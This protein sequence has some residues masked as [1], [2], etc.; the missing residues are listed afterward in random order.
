MRIARY[1]NERDNAPEIAD[2]EWP[3][4]VERLTRHTITPCSRTPAPGFDLCARK[5]CGH[6]S[7]EAWSPA[8]LNPCPAKCHKAGTRSDCGGGR[9]HRLNANVVAITVAVFDLDHLPAAKLLEVAATI[10]GSGLAYIMHSTHSHDLEGDNACL[11]LMLPLS[12]AV[13]AAEYPKLREAVIRRFNLPADPQTKDLARLFFLPSCPSD[14]D[15]IAEHG[16]GGSIAVEHFLAEAGAAPAPSAVAPAPSVDSGGSAPSTQ[17]EGS[18]VDLEALRDRLRAVNKAD[19]KE[20]ARRILRGEPLA[21]EGSRD[22]TLNRAVSLVACAVPAET[23]SEAILELL[24]PSVLAMPGAPPPGDPDWLRLAAYKLERARER[25]TENDKRRDEFNA[26]VRRRLAR[27]SATSTVADEPDAPPEDLSAPYTAEQIERWM[28]EQGAATYEEFERRWIV[29]R[30]KA[31]WIFVGGAYRQPITRD[32]LDVSLPRDLARAPVELHKITAEGNP[33]PAKVPELLR[34]YA[35]VARD[36]QAS[37]ALQR[38]FYDATS[39]TF[40]EAVRPLRRITP[41]E[42]PEVQTWLELLGAGFEGT[43]REQRDKLLDWIATVSRL[44]RQSCALYFDGAPGVGKGL[45]ANGL[46][47]LWTTGGPTEL[48]RVLGGFNDSLINCPLL[49][50][51]ESLPAVKGITAELRRLIGSTQ[52]TLRRLYLPACNLDGSIRMIIAGN[53]DRLLDTGE[54]LSTHD[55]EAVAGRF[56]YVDAR[57]PDGEQHPAAAYLED[58]G[59]TPVVN[60]WITD[61]MIAEHALFLQSTRQVNEGARFIVEGK[62]AE[63]HEHLATGSGIAGLVCEWLVRHLSD[64]GTARAAAPGA[65]ALVFVGEGEVWA[66]TEALA[67][68]AAWHARV[69]SSN[70]PSATK[71]GRALRNLSIGKERVK[72]GEVQN[73]YHRVKPSLLLSWAERSQVGDVDALRT[74]IAAPCAEIARAKKARGG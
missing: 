31:F 15:A 8:I 72:V 22:E 73:T 5:D 32:D 35:T 49:F 7:G 21:E 19:S 24:R 50:A 69:P 6:K 54:D 26:E 36:V 2:L 11:R 29:Q 38:S 52:R 13:T 37:L 53:N 61:D 18:P 27:D 33:R 41:R 1:R 55:L 70:V 57:A 45:L 46:A 34:Q 28:N 12:R 48:S 47:R 40:F 30:A 25:R 60:K 74:R 66:A 39:Q 23:P 71:I 68:E 43:N 17:G 14:A 58:L 3:Q 65:R 44:D 42:H 63:F 59:G 62:A 51:D 20:L 56:F 9:F 67:G 4:L 10:E 16:P 64:P